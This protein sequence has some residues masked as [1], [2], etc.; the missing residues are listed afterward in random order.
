MKSKSLLIVAGI[1]IILI[2]WGVSVYNWL[3]KS[4]VNVEQEWSNVETQYQRRSD[5]IGNLVATVKGYA[6]HEKTTLNEVIAARTAATQTKIDSKDLTP[7]KLQQFQ[8]TQ[9]ELSSALG[10]LLVTV[11]RYPDLKANQNFLELQAQL[12]GTENRI[13]VARQRYNEVSA[14]FN[15][16]IRVFPTNIPAGLFGFSQKPFFEADKEAKQA[17]KVEF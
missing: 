4:E 5:L 11:E 8:E 12:E 6:E 13:Q 9:G 17:P 7:E 1:A 15:K 2:I 14:E 10:R 16:K 3:V